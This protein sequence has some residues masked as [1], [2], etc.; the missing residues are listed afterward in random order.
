MLYCGSFSASLH[1]VSLCFPCSVHGS[2]LSFQWECLLTGLSSNCLIC[3]IHY[4]LEFS[5]EF[6]SVSPLVDFWQTFFIF[7]IFLIICMILRW[8]FCHL[9]L[10]CFPSMF[11]WLSCH[12]TSL[13]WQVLQGLLPCVWWNFF[14][15]SWGLFLLYSVEF[16]PLSFLPLVPVMFQTLCAPAVSPVGCPTV[17]TSFPDA[18]ASPVSYL[19]VLASLSNVVTPSSVFSCSWLS[20][21]FLHVATCLV[22]CYMM[23]L[24]VIH[25]LPPYFR[26]HPRSAI[27]LALRC[28]SSLFQCLPLSCLFDI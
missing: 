23:S 28:F 10:P 24:M 6:Q 18:A 7:S 15:S 25:M 16:P 5:Y 2:G 17:L 27:D 8:L 21:M 14:H 19:T 1:M 22:I 20:A 4:F 9:E 26:I 12:F 3:F 13:W 11:T